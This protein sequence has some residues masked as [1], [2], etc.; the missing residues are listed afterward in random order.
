[1]EMVGEQ[2]DVDVDVDDGRWLFLPVNGSGDSASY[3]H[4]ETTCHNYPATASH[5]SDAGG[6]KNLGDIKHRI[7]D[8]TICCILS[9]D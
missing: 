6:M 2:V 4:A 3:R 9:S 1:M 7:A 5:N 8:L